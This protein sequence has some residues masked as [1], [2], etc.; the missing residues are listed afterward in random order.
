MLFWATDK[1]I[2]GME[3]STAAIAVYNIGVTFNSM[4]TNLSTAVSG[5]LQPKVT[6]MVKQKPPSQ[7]FLQCLSVLAGCNM[8]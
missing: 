4:F 8:R 6:I 1:V 5:V 2:L 7:S 3:A